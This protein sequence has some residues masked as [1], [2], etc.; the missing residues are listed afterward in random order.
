VL[1]NLEAP[2]IFV[3]S[4][5]DLDEDE[6]PAFRKRRREQGQ[7]EELLS[8]L[9][10]SSLFTQIWRNIPANIGAFGQKK[11]LAKEVALMQT[12]TYFWR[13]SGS[14]AVA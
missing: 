5:A 8:F 4:D 3:I 12:K 10:A 9:S 14:S 6:T 1:L 13:P 7:V 2:C 11:E